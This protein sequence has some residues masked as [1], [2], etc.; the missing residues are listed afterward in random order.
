M[1]RNVKVKIYL[2]IVSC[3]ILLTFNT[4][5][6]YKIDQNNLI[7]NQLIKS[8]FQKHL[9]D[10][11]LVLQLAKNINLMSENSAFEILDNPQ[12]ESESGEI[13]HLKDIEIDKYKLLLRYNEF[14]CMNCVYKEMGNIKE[15]VESIGVENVLLLGA[16]RNRNYLFRN[17]RINQIKLPVFNMPLG[18]LKNK[19][20]HINLPYMFLVDNNWRVQNFFIPHK[21]LPQLSRTYFEIIKTKFSK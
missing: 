6:L 15:L 21:E 16:Y 11:M 5:N 1:E 20:E 4:V 14:T 9:A 3:L 13:I 2:L 17:K 8:V 18:A 7:Y 10:S 12:L 19:V